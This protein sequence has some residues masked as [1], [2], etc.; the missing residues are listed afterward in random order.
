[1][2]SIV[3]VSSETISCNGLATF[4][5]VFALIPGGTWSYEE[6]LDAEEDVCDSVHISTE[7]IHVSTSAGKLVEIHVRLN[8][9]VRMAQLLH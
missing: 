9:Q 3:R 5:F 4:V 7:T 8:T 1:M 6:A 2:H